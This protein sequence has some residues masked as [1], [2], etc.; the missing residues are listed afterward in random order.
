MSLRNFFNMFAAHK[1][2][3]GPSYILRISTV[4]V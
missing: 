3:N 1:K 4:S 2:Q